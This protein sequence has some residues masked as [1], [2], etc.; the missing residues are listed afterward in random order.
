MNPLIETEKSL[1]IKCPYNERDKYFEGLVPKGMLSLS[2]EKEITLAG[3][4]FYPK[5]FAESSSIEVGLSFGEG[6]HT[7]LRIDKG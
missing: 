4:S 6:A 7:L 3:V 5:P 1:F 2:E